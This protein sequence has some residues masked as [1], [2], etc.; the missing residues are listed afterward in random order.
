MLFVFP[1]RIHIGID[2]GSIRIEHRIL[3]ICD[4]IDD[5]GLGIIGPVLIDGI[6]AEIPCPS[7]DGAPRR[8]D[9]SIEDSADSDSPMDT[10]GA[11]PDD[12]L[13]LVIG[14]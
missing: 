8:V 13:N 4:P 5:I 14:S 12:A 6:L 2:W 11:H 1:N 7:I 3:R 10:R 9:G